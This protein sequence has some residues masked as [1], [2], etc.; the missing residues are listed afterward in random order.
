MKRMK[1]ILAVAFLA[2]SLI[3][4]CVVAPEPDYGVDVA[5][6]LPDV[7]VLDHGPY[8]HYRDYH[9]RYENDRWH[10]AR[11]RNG[12]WRELPRSHWPKEVRR[13]GTY[14]G[15]RGGEFRRY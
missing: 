6:P 9:Y 3:T 10:Y 4:G 1:G 5:P 15:G 13:G 14:G 11:E 12:P 7:V 2:S 8:Y